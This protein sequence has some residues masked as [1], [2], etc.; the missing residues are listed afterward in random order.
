MAILTSG[1]TTQAAAAEPITVPFSVVDGALELPAANVSSASLTV[2]GQPTCVAVLAEGMATF[3][4][5]AGL[6]HLDEGV[7]A[8]LKRTPSG[9][10]EELVPVALWPAVRLAGGFG[11]AFGSLA[12]DVAAWVRSADGPWV[13][14]DAQRPVPAAILSEWYRGAVVR[15]ARTSGQDPRSWTVRELWFD[16]RLDACP[17]RVED[18]DRV[19]NSRKVCID[20]HPLADAPLRIH[21]REVDW[22]LGALYSVGSETRDLE[23]LPGEWLSV[24]VINA[25]PGLT[26]KPDAKGSVDEPTP[27]ATVQGTGEG[28]GSAET[29][30]AIASRRLVFNFAPRAMGTV[31]RIDLEAEG[32]SQGF[33]EITVRKFYIGAVRIGIAGTGTF[34]DHDYAVDAAPGS[35]TERVTDRMGADAEF[36]VGPEIVLG[37]SGFL[38]PRSYDMSRPPDEHRSACGRCGASSY[39]VSHLAPYVGLG[40]VGFDGA[41]LTPLASVYLGMEYE[42]V[43]DFGIVLAGIATR[44]E[45]LQAAYQV[46]DATSGTDVTRPVVR[47]GIAMVLNV[48]PAFFRAHPTLSKFSGGQR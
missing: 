24:E 14:I 47:G 40:V 44:G 7:D 41:E 3:R 30:H 28:T 42:P 17:T 21:P 4:D 18:P 20:L 25:P 27:R 19:Y 33:L 39:L 6:K 45:A 15:V 48:S 34:D 13:K 38:R 36:V 37:Y 12:G 22:P 32:R 43:P 1:V 11:P 10:T 26:V 5:C 35:S 2:E 16:P 9:G 8:I 31:W 46:G 29:K 23:L